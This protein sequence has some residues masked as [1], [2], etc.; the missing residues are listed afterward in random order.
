MTTPR[1]LEAERRVERIE[2][3]DATQWKKFKKHKKYKAFADEYL[4]AKCMTDFWYYLKYGVYWRAMKHYYEPLHGSQGIAGFLQDWTIEENGVRIPIKTKFL[5]VAREH[6]KSQEAMAWV[7]WELMRDQNLRV[8]MRS[9]K[10]PAIFGVLAGI[11]D[12]FLSKPFMHRFPWCKPAMEGSRKK[13]W[14]ED[15]ILLDRD[16]S[17]VKTNSIHCYGFKSDNTGE[18]FDIGLYDDWET[19]DT[20][21]SDDLRPQLFEKWKLDNPL[22]EGGSRRINIGTPY[23]AKA[24]IMAGVNHKNIFEDM[25]YG[26]FVQPCTVNVFDAP[27]DAHEP[28][29]LPDRQTFRCQ[30]AGFPT[31]EANL[32]LCQVRINFFSKIAKDTVI[33]VREVEWNDGEHIRVN[34]PIPEVLGQPLELTVGKSKPV[35]PNRFT[36]DSVDS[37]PEP[38][39]GYLINRKSLEGAK[40]EQGSYHYS[41]Q[42]DLEPLDPESLIFNP[43]DIQEVNLEDV[44]TENIRVYRASDFASAKKTAASSA[45]VTGVYHKTG[46]YIIH[47]YHE[48]R[49]TPTDLLLEL[50]LGI[51]RCKDMGFPIYRNFFETA[52]IEATVA[53]FMD[54]AEKNTFEFFKTL[55]GKYERAA[56]EFFEGIPNIKIKSHSISRGGYQSKNQRIVSAQP[57]VEAKQVYIVKGIRNSEAFYDEIGTFTMDS[58]DTFDLLDCLRDI[59]VVGKPPLENKKRPHEKRNLFNEHIKRAQ[60]RY[61]ADRFL[62]SRGAGVR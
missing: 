52:A 7:T 32:E 55:G 40:I 13:K 17:G 20:A 22:F 42:M 30:G 56:I 11:K 62:K 35:A 37:T 54:K 25:N 9:H 53:N 49:A 41:C 15:T 34:R 6:C 57:Q 61:H 26:T 59:I 23:H 44:P 19:K 5:V 38:K 31:I 46:V 21:N 3:F 51:L 58:K 33:E 18:H 45:I 48:N 12:I 29:L 14:A 36:H 47:I 24:F 27:F 4:T 16:M 43:A 50:F 28:I 39:K 10:D 2:N 60:S 1:V 8:M